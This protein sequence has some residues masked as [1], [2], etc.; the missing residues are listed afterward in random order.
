[1]LSDETRGTHVRDEGEDR[2]RSEANEPNEV[3]LSAS[4]GRVGLRKSLG[5]AISVGLGHKYEGGGSGLSLIVI[6]VPLAPR[7]CV[8]M[9]TFMKLFVKDRNTRTTCGIEKLPQTIEEAHELVKTTWHYS[10]KLELVGEALVEWQYTSSGARQVASKELG[11][12]SVSNFR[13]VP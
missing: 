12:I 6:L 8:N 2:K 7:T 3:D 9:E 5:D 11:S 1:M 13:L 4:I 10:T